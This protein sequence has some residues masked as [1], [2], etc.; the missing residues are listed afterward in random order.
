M[1]VASIAGK[2]AGVPA[3][4][5]RRGSAIPI[6]NSTLNRYLFRNVI[7]RFMANSQETKRTILAN[8]P[9]L[10]PEEKIRVIY[11]GVY[12]PRYSLETA[13]LYR[14]SG[15]EIV[16]GSAGRLSE[17]KGHLYLL[18][19]MSI[20]KHDELQFKLL[21]AGEGRLLHTLQR[22]ARKLEIEDRVV[23]LGFV[24][25][26]PAFFNSID[27]FLLTSHYE[28][29]GYVIAEAMASRKPVV[30]FDIKS[31]AEII[32]HGVT[33]Y[34]TSTK[35]AGEL[36]RRVKE[37]AGDRAL[38]EKMGASGRLRVEEKFSFEKNRAEILELITKSNGTKV[39]YPP[40]EA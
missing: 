26:M 12:L 13:P 27:I 7:T 31:S 19:M 32:E 14:N 9:M 3:I 40:A 6:R 29:F 24:E 8:N 34:L 5:Y 17:E 30:A 36:A 28:G 25:Q 4:I 18:E 39:P 16:L 23:F 20:L 1:K 33:G 10:V 22:K 35:S 38:R 21:I 37:L 15:K 2:I 11:N